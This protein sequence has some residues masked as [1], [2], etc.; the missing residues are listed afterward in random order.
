MKLLQFRKQKTLD[1]ISEGDLKIYLAELEYQ[2]TALE[3]EI[4]ELNSAVRKQLISCTAVQRETD[5]EL[6]SREL[7]NLSELKKDAVLRKLSVQNK[8]HA[9]I[10][11]LHLKQ[12]SQMKTQKRSVLDVID[13]DSIISYQEVV[14]E[15]NDVESMR[16]ERILENSLGAETYA[17]IRSIVYALRVNSYSVDDAEKDI[18]EL[19]VEQI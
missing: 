3:R 11:L 17:K 14:H 10:R 15:Q 1:K 19:I 16:V 13:I 7:E 12:E 2:E 4:A 18:E 6:L 9:V 5:V 8:R